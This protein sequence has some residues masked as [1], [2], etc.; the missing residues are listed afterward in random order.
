MAVCQ[1][2]RSGQVHSKTDDHAAFAPFQEY[3]GQLGVAQQKVVRP[4]QHERLTWE[5][6]VDRFDEAQPRDERERLRRRIATSDLYESAA[7]EI[8]GLT[9]PLASLAASARGL[10]QGN[11]PVPFYGTWIGK[12]VG[13]GRAGTLDDPDAAQKI[14]PAARSVIALRG[15]ISRY[16]IGETMIAARKISAPCTGCR[17]RANGCAASSMYMTF[18]IRR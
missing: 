14:D 6:S 17:T 2:R 11:E 13:V 16:P 9:D 5:A 1:R 4:F 18:T 12:Q 10:G 15:P 3:A 8:T 7:E